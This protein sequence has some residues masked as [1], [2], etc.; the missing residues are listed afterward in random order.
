MSIHQND[1]TF[2]YLL[3]IE[4]QRTFNV[5]NNIPKYEKLEMKLNK[6]KNKK[7]IKPFLHLKKTDDDVFIDI[8]ECY[9]HWHKFTTLYNL[10][11]NPTAIDICLNK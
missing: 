4:H 11:E 10:S 1:F 6:N 7:V 3:N 8:I 5:M 2:P 9:I